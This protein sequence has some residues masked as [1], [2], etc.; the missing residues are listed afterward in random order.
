MTP[1]GLYPT[2]E[3][4]PRPRFEV[5]A[6]CEPDWRPDEVSGV[7]LRDLTLRHLAAVHVMSLDDDGLRYVVPRL[8]ELLVRTPA[9]VLE[10]RIADLKTRI[11][12]WPER[13]ALARWAGEVWAQLLASHPADLGYFSDCPAALD[14]L[15]WCG[16]PVT[17]R[18]DDLL[19]GSAAAHLADLVDAVY[20]LRDPFET[21]SRA[22][23]LRW[24]EQPAVGERLQEAFFDAS[25]EIAA[26]LS[27]AHHL[28][29]ACVSGR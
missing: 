15:D 5:C 18:L 8:F 17:T 28:W 6:Q 26:R 20:T 2:F 7:A 23:V 13:D 10:F 19:A 25:D 9:P 11:A 3:R 14:L 4:Y 24:I 12:S 21:V 27:A 22:T 16:V 29:T 1:D